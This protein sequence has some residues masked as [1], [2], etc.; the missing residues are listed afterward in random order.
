[1]SSHEV[2]TR[3][4]HTLHWGDTRR[5]PPSSSSGVPSATRR[6]GARAARGGELLPRP[7]RPRGRGPTTPRRGRPRARRAGGRRRWRRWRRRC[8]CRRRCRPS[9]ARW[10]VARAAHGLFV[11]R[12]VRSRQRPPSVQGDAAWPAAQNPQYYMRAHATQAARRSPTSRARPRRRQAA[13]RQLSG[14][15]P[16]CGSPCS[17]GTSTTGW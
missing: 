9:R 14:V 2:T 16:A 6:R 4:P 7:P 1:M 8:R 10:T 12:P 5:A 15:G 17:R 11:R 3:A 13:P